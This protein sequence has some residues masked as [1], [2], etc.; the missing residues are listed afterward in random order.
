MTVFQYFKLDIILKQDQFFFD[1][2]MK[3]DL[4]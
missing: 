2:V 1:M 4:K 3:R